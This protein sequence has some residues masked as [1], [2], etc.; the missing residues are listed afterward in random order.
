GVATGKFSPP[1]GCGVGNV[2]CDANGDGIND[3]GALLS[4]DVPFNTFNTRAE[5]DVQARFTDNISAYMKLRAH[6]DGTSAFTD[7]HM[8][9]HFLADAHWGDGRG[10]V[11]EVQGNDYMLDLPSL[12][13]DINYGSFW[14]RVGQQQI[15]WGEALFFRVL[16]VPNGLD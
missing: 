8:A 10:T 6:F 5:I 2:L 7:A 12:Y 4:D 9:Q 14:V 3:R 1:G 11:L 13:A 15:A 16:D